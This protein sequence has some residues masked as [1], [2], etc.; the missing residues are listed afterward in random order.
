MGV[1]K[2]FFNGKNW[3]FTNSPFSRLSP[4][5][6]S[7]LPLRRPP[8]QKER[9]QIPNG[10]SESERPLRNKTK[11]NFK[12]R[13]KNETYNEKNDKN[14]DDGKDGKDGRNGKQ[15]NKQTNRAEK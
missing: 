5:T 13:N 11:Q 8:R 2:S 15:T 4:S 10:S 12:K 3:S 14:G 1:L 6:F 7:L 9:R